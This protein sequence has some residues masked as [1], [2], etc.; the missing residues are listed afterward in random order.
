MRVSPSLGF[1]KGKLESISLQSDSLFGAVLIFA[2]DNFYRE[3]RQCKGPNC[4]K[5]FFVKRKG[6][7]FCEPNGRCAKAFERLNKKSKAK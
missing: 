3:L 4:R 7:M 5:L 6:R 2:I 1:K